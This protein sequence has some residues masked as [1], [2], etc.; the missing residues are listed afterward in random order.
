MSRTETKKMERKE[1]LEA[2]VKKK[3]Q[4]SS[5]LA[6]VIPTCSPLK[7]LPEPRNS[8]VATS[9][10]YQAGRTDQYMYYHITLKT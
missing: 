6:R 7:M 4:S 2:Y 1:I 3:I 8:H 5:D 10:V 9:G